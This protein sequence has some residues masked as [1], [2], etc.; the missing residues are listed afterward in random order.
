MS[1]TF[2]RA[3]RGIGDA[4]D[5]EH[6]QWIGRHGIVALRIDRRSVDHYRRFQDRCRRVPGAPASRGEIGGVSRR[7]AVDR[8]DTANVT[9]DFLD[10]G[11]AQDWTGF[12]QAEPNGA[13]NLRRL[14]AE[15]AVALRAWG[16]AMH[17]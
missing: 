10:D 15:A 11:S 2:S 6:D 14:D 7:P 13:A 8:E 4:A 3:G 1:G 17:R 5:R 9:V 16:G 12:R